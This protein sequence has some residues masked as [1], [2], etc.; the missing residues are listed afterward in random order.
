[1]S[2]YRL[3]H[4]LI[5]LAFIPFLLYSLV[6]RSTEGALAVAIAAI[7]VITLMLLNHKFNH[8]SKSPGRQT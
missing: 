1:M 2:K 5:V 6:Q 7:V 4:T 3:F 8:P